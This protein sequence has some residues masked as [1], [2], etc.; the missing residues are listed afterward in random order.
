MTTKTTTKDKERY[1]EGIGRRKEAVARVRLIPEAKK[2]AFLINQRELH[3]YFPVKELRATA[4]ETLTVA[5]WEGPANISVIVRGG[6]LKSQAE[7]I[8]LGLARVLIDIDPELKPKLKQAKLLTRDARVKERYKFGLK[9][10]RRAAQW[11]KR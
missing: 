10:A 11:S 6:G 9:K 1:I 8:R 2:P 4:K 3:D 7:A 5:G